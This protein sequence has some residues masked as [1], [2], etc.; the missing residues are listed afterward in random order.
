MLHQ[1]LPRWPKA[2]D[3]P[4]LTDRDIPWGRH[5]LRVG[6][7]ALGDE[8]SYRELA[9]LAIEECA[10]LTAKLRQAT[11]TITMLRTELRRL[12]RAA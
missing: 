10:R 5:G 6:I 9:R 8:R 3:P 11:T 12:R 1:I 7:I 2:D 4:D